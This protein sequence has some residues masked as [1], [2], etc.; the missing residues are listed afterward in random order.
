M[1][2]VY[3]AIFHEEEGYWVEFPDLEGCNTCG[4]T[5]EEAMEY[6]QE[7][8]G[9]YLVSLMEDKKEI[10][11]ASNLHVLTAEEGAIINYVAADVEK[12]RR[13]TKAVKKTLSIPAWLAEEA[14]S[15]NLSLS[16]V[17]QDG[18]KSQLGI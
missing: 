2:T 12:Y 15:H 18:I 3:P 5:I 11:E 7:A 16:K 17:L 9:L 4:A 13:N 1:L 10:P 8:L 14:E 6:A